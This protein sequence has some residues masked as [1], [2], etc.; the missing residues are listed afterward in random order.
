M[1]FKKIFLL[2]GLAG[3]L[4]AQIVMQTS[5]DSILT[6]RVE[7]DAD[8]RLLPWFQPH[9]P[10]AAYAHVAQLASEFLLNSVPVYEP[11]GVKMYFITCCFQGPQMTQNNEFIAEDWMHNPA[12]VW[13]GLVQSLV[14]DYRVYSGDKSYIDL[15]RGMLDFQLE[16]GLTPADWVWPDVPYASA[17]PFVITYQGAMRWETDGMRGDGLH[18]IEPDKIGELGIAFLN[19]YKVTL[20]E[21][22]LTA[23]VHCADA[24]AEHVRDVR[25]GPPPFSE[26]STIKSPW[27]FRVN[28]RNGLIVSEYCSNVIEPIRLF[29]ELLRL[30]HRLNIASEQ[31]IAYQKARDLAGEWLFSINGPMKTSI[32]N[33]YF[34]DVPNDPDRSNRVQI[35]PLE[36]L[37]HLIKHPQLDPNLDKDAP[38]LIHWVASNFATEGMDAIKEQTWCYA[39]MGSHTARYASL[40]A[41][42]YEYTQDDWYKDQA[43]R[44]FNL[45]TYMCHPNGVVSVGPDW[46]GSWWSDG[47]GDYIRHFMEGLAAIPEWAPVDQDHL[48]KSTSVIQ[49]LEYSPKQTS[50]TTFDAEAVEVLRLTKK[51]S[52]VQSGIT[53]LKERTNLDAP[54]WTWKKLNKGGVM[55]VR[56]SSGEV[57]VIK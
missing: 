53:F 48:L 5:T 54:G 41:L 46:P 15:V 1:R 32:W 36:T 9:V 25:P 39:P 33:A 26:S 20:E 27:P 16:H 47:Y 12:C 50:Y 7:R 44:F 11:L 49:A 8:G 31:T 30:Q 18:C 3:T 14:L 37:R 51:P 19:F 2:L 42:W 21:R 35:T 56:H 6:H 28:A 17:D 29:D 57:R 34:E 4:P 10:G 55:Q 40:C 22:F 23:A 24:L 13:A 52:T 38:A 45:A 43:E